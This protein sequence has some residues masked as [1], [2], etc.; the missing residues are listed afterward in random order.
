MSTTT[1]PGISRGNVKTISDAITRDGIATN[2]RLARYRL[3]TGGVS[4]AYR[5]SQAAMSRPP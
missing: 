3:S 4:P 2:R 5:S 1:S